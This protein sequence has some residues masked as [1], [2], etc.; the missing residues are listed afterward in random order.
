MH[1]H[2]L[3]TSPGLPTAFVRHLLP[4]LHCAGRQQPAAPYLTAWE[5]AALK[6][7]SYPACR[8]AENLS[9][10]T[11]REV[12]HACSNRTIPSAE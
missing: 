7:S 10:F 8:Y 3:A 2:L 11:D 5:V 12:V 4:L 9:G 6:E 1:G